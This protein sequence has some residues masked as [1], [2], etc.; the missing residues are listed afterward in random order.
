M[1]ACVKW[2]SNFLAAY[3]GHPKLVATAPG[4]VCVENLTSTAFESSFFSILVEI[5]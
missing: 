1:M 2:P 5:L 3:E 4:K